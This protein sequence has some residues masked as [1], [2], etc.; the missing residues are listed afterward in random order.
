MSINTEQLS[1]VNRA[2]VDSLL[3]LANTAL[4]SAERITELNLNTVRATLEDGTSGLQSMIFAQDPQ[5]VLEAQQALA[6]PALE[7]AAAYSRSMTEIATQTQQEMAQM[8]EAQF[9]DFQKSVA[10]L[11]D[12]AVKSAPAGSEGAIAVL[13]SSISAANTAFGN[14]N[15]LAKQFSDVTQSS[16][17][18]ATSRKGK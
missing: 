7:K 3:A 18:A 11:L 4:V 5:A 14:M 6:Q 15:T 10:I 17:K 8:L 9:G 2:T 12:K 16:I 13:Q 1:A